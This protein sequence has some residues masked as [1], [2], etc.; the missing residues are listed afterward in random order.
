MSWDVVKQAGAIDGQHVSER[1]CN[2]LLK[3]SEFESLGRGC[4][5]CCGL[6]AVFS[7]GVFR[8]LRRPELRCSHGD[9]CWVRWI[10]RTRH[11]WPEALDGLCRLRGSQFGEQENRKD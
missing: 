9:W 5:A 8:W 11:L 1:L 10:A 6:W 7:A 2:E 4:A 3:I